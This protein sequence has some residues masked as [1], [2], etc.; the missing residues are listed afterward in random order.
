[1]R[2]PHPVRPSHASWP[3][4]PPPRPAFTVSCIYTGRI[5]ARIHARRLTHTQT[6]SQSNALALSLTRAQSPVLKPIV[7]VRVVYPAT[8]VGTPLARFVF[9]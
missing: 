9:P 8:Y 4:R 3:V 5:H 2:P 6:Q 1:M 7:S